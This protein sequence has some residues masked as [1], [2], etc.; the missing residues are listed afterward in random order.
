MEMGKGGRRA[1][2]AWE[3]RPHPRADQPFVEEA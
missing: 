2:G 3:P 1:E